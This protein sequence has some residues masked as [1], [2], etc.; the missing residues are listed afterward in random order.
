MLKYFVE[1]LGTFVFLSVILNTAFGE[2]GKTGMVGLPIGL[3]LA[4][5]IFFGGNVSGG[6]FNPAVSLMMVAGNKMASSELLP[7]VSAQL[8]GGLAALQ[9]Y[10]RT[11][12]KSA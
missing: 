2:A 1:F 5:V 11:N 10:R 4:A 12:S 8:L 9:F 7:Y 3:A 6:H